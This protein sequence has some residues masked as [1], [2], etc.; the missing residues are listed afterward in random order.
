MIFRLFSS[1][2]GRKTIVEPDNTVPL[3][4]KMDDVYLLEDGTGIQPADLPSIL[5]AFVVTVRIFEIMEGARR[6]D[7]GSFNHNLRLP[8]LT[9]V[10]QLNE[11]IDQIENGL[12]S[13][14]KRDYSGDANTPRDAL[15]KLQAEAV[16]TRYTYTFF[17]PYH[18]RYA[19]ATTPYAGSFTSCD[20]MY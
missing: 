3:P 15:F 7:Y 17:L 13:H 20:L 2:F 8:E 6:I 16:M 14:L 11:K 1:L 19:Y 4:E 5:D 10:L 18:N 12:P 9:E